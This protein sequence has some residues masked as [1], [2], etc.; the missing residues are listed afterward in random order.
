ML[1]TLLYGWKKYSTV[2]RIA[3]TCD[4]CSLKMLN[5]LYI[6][7]NIGL[8]RVFILLKDCLKLI[9]ETNVV[10]I[11]FQERDENL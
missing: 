3:W 11:L 9:V 1:M 2:T 5:Y 6:T 7:N 8:E 4:Y 10:P